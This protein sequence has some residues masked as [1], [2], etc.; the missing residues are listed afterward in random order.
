MNRETTW[1]EKLETTLPNGRVVRFNPDYK[2]YQTD[3]SG[4]SRTVPAVIVFVKESEEVEKIVAFANKENIPITVRGAGTGKVGGAVP[5]YGGIIISLENMNQILEI[6]T[7]N[8]VAVVEPGV[9]LK[10]LQH[11][12][13][14]HQ[15]FYPP[16]PA[17]WDQ[18]T[19][20][21]TVA[22]N[23]GGPRAVKYGVTGDYVVGLEGVYA[24]GE[25]F[26]LGGKLVKNVAGYDLIRLLVGSE[27]TLGVITKIILKLVQLPAH[28]IDIV[29]PFDTMQNALS[30]ISESYKSPFSVASAEFLDAV[31]VREATKGSDLLIPSNAS[32][33]V[34]FKVDGSTQSVVDEL[35]GHV[36]DYC[37]QR[38]V[39]SP[40]IART[41][42]E[43]ETI[44]SVR[45]GVSESLKRC[46][47]HKISHDITVPP[48]SIGS[49]MDVL[50]KIKTPL[51]VVG[52]GHLGDG[53]I[54]VNVLDIEGIPNWSSEQKRVS[55]EVIKICLRY[56]GT[57]SGE[58]GIGITKRDYMAQQFSGKDLSIF[59][60]L[61]QLFD[62][63]Q[64]L[65]KGKV[66]K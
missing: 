12:V 23:A 18:C 22:V 6:D 53:N 21:G 40:I 15:L 47:R 27:G 5:E 37:R 46:S 63:N 59:S 11:K 24:S 38:S 2:N 50:Y 34:I 45:R 36:Q 28:E 57:L 19:I 65:N 61:K 16:D 49:V 58:H 64:I 60:G 42:S 29:V 1:I 10:D 4:V 56:G 8:R 33:L 51:T 17:S 26:K 62:P 43:K 52:Y 14:K 25:P 13:S 9:I 39:Y 31:C 35:S 32:I 54:H 7:A 55:E 3:A 48:A 20:G 30:C 66:I 44:W 41:E